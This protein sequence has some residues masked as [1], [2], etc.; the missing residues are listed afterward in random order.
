MTDETLVPVFMPPLAYMLGHHERQKGVPLTEQEV[1]AVRD[2]SVAMMMRRSVADQM[3]QKRGYRDI[4]AQ[5]CWHEWQ[6]MRKQL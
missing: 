3:S 4:D 1:L 2:K 5:N 6:E